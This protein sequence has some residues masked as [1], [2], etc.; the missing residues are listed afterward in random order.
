MM[1]DLFVIKVAVEGY[2]EVKYFHERLAESTTS[3]E[4]RKTEMA[5]ADALK[6]AIEM[7][8]ALIPEL[9]NVP[10]EAP[11]TSVA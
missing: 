8:E 9:K 7:L 4:V 3:N 10:S 6:F 11:A 5:Q 2:K 1:V